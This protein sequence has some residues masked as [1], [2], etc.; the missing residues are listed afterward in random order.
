MGKRL[1][2]WS[3]IAL[4]LFSMAMGYT[5]NSYIREHILQKPP[6]TVAKFE[7][8]H[9]TVG[10]DTRII[11][12]KEYRRCGHVV[13]S[14][15]NYRNKII[16]LDNEGLKQYFKTA[17]GYAIS[18]AD[19]TL[20]IHQTINNYCPDDQEQFKLKEH[21]GYIAVYTGA[22]ENEILLR[23]TAIKLDLLPEKIQKDIRS[24]KYTFQD[25]ATLNDTLENFDEYI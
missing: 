10:E 15:F 1:V 22:E 12:E 19:N 25:E 2:T 13:V 4:A 9:Q 18:F 7:I 20:I 8:K 24:G 3:F 11:F 23:V 17:E 14:G 6:K 21:G 16:G 5:F